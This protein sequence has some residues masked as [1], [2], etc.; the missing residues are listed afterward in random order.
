MRFY[1]ITEYGNTQTNN[2]NR[3]SVSKMLLWSDTDVIV[4]EYTF[5]ELR[6]NYKIV[7][8]DS[9]SNSRTTYNNYEEFVEGVKGKHLKELI[10]YKFCQKWVSTETFFAG[11][12]EMEVADFGEGS[13]S[14][15]NKAKLLKLYYLH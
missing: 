1:L 15:C 2:Y 13:Y 8:K 3:K 5:D 10:G 12:I 14:D 9:N 4:N 6:G 7:V 11:G